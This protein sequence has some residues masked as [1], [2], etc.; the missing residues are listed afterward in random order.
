MSIKRF[1]REFSLR[2]LFHLH[3]ATF[4][5]PCLSACAVC[6]R[7]APPKPNPPLAGIEMDENYHSIHKPVQQ[8]QLRLVKFGQDGN[9][10]SAVLEAFSLE[11]PIPKYYTLSYTWGLQKHVSGA[12]DRHLLH[13]GKEEF[14]VLAALRS[15]FQVLRS[16]DAELQDTWW[17]ID[18]I[19]INLENMEERSQQVQ[20]MGEIYRRAEKVIIWLGEPSDDTDRAIDFLHLL[21]EAKMELEQRQTTTLRQDIR[22]LFQQDKYEQQ[23]DALTNFCQRGWWSRV[24]TLQEY[25]ISPDASFWCGRRT[26][27]RFTLE[28]ALFCTDR[29]MSV[30]F[31]EEN[32]GF[33]RAWTRRRIHAWVQKLRQARGA[34]ASMGLVALAAYNSCFEATDDRDRL[35]GLKGLATERYVLHADY[36]LNVEETYQRFAKGFIEHYKSLDVICFASIHSASPES[37][38]PS[39]VPDWRATKVSPMPVPLMVSQS[40]KSH[41]GNFRAFSFFENKTGEA[42][43]C[44][45]A[46]KDLQAVYAFSG[47]KLITRGIIVD[48]VDG[49]A[50]SQ[51]AE[52]VQSSISSQLSEVTVAS[53]CLTV[54][55]SEILHCV[56]RCL[57]LGRKDRYLRFAVPQDEFFHDFAWLCAQLVKGSASTVRSNVV[58]PEEFRHWLDWTRHLRIQGYS[59]ENILDSSKEVTSIGSSSPDHV[60]DEWMADTFLHRFFDTIVRMR[61]RLMVTRNGV[62]GLVPEKASKGDLVCI[63]F[64]CSVPV[65]LRPC[66]DCDGEETF[67]FVGE[68][69]LD[70]YMEGQGLDDPGSDDP[71]CSVRDFCIE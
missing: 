14:P 53:D 21:N 33:R 5:N 45:T 6:D 55:V 48:V 34:G 4:W 32:Q 1:N 38:V 56:C 27:S 69:F 67:T 31:K 50:G 65:L 43:L 42:V 11:G 66:K 18:S 36:T 7:N 28:G 63:L 17:W 22:R 41:V 62:I 60:L 58:V 13:I 52:L 20:L 29:C 37:T 23:W 10:T 15:F 46:S 39:W 8:D 44:Y 35:Y 54:P 26:V 40:A 61:L 30:A 12:I 16:K 47:S 57:V 2:H 68:C 59:L 25:A 71:G 49:I 9:R 19:C 64:G 3:F 24:W 70:G 51:N